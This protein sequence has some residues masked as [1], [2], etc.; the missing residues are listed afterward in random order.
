MPYTF[1]PNITKLET[2]GLVKVTEISSSGETI[3]R[4]KEVTLYALESTVPRDN[5]ATTTH[6]VQIV[7][8][9]DLPKAVELCR[10]LRG[11]EE[12]KY[13]SFSLLTFTGNIELRVANGAVDWD[14]KHVYVMRTRNHQRGVYRHVGNA[15]LEFVY[16]FANQ[17]DAMGRTVLEASDSLGMIPYPFY[18]QFGY[19]PGHY[20]HP[21][22]TK[23]SR[24]KKLELCDAADERMKNAKKEGKEPAAEDIELLSNVDMFLPDDV[25]ATMTK[26]FS[27][28]PGTIPLSQ[29]KLG[30]PTASSDEQK[31]VK[32]SGP[33]SSP[34]A[35]AS[36]RKESKLKSRG[37]QPLEPPE[38]NSHDR[39]NQLLSHAHQTVPKAKPKPSRVDTTS[40]SAT[41]EGSSPTQKS[42]LARQMLAR[43]LKIS[44]PESKIK[45]L[46]FKAYK[47]ELKKQ[48]F[49][50]SHLLDEF[51]HIREDKELLQILGVKEEL[52]SLYRE[53]GASIQEHRISKLQKLQ[54]NNKQGHVETT[55]EYLE[56][57][58]QRLRAELGEVKLNPDSRRKSWDLDK[59]IKRKD[60][61]ENCKKSIR[62]D[63]SVTELRSVLNRA[64]KE[65]GNLDTLFGRKNTTEGLQNLLELLP[66]SQPAQTH[67]S[68]LS[69]PRFR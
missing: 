50:N 39:V 3:T 42:S 30:T 26:R 44:A 45:Q 21:K 13:K 33:A 37:E 63:M 9:E 22:E 69:A 38:R 14:P 11:S 16:K 58:V 41:S 1:D 7:T 68:P 61:L 35:S 53:V 17:N 24:A 15:E 27:P 31:Q 8:E 65:S 47:S 20:Q 43:H 62:D 55:K 10:N 25:I 66:Q 52:K 64:L 5:E 46:D 67:A 34:Q 12:D 51:D 32:S 6:F 59:K 36:E 57:E 54:I 19:V 49:N 2:K 60:I 18:R 48:N 29:F 28:S 56:M 40:L 23:E 4:E